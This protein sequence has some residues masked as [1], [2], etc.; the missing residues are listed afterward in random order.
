MLARASRVRAARDRDR[1]RTAEV[2]GTARDLRVK[3]LAV[4]RRLAA[5]DEQSVAA[6]RFCGYRRLRVRARLPACQDLDFALAWLR[7]GIAALSSGLQ[8]LRGALR[9]V[10]GRTPA[11]ALD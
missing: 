11:C 8:V 3:A 5:E 2:P 9:L 7:G 6:L 10:L 4:R 1:E